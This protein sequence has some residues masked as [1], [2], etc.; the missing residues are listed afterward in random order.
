MF[1]ADDGEEMTG[2]VIGRIFGSG[3]VEWTE[4]CILCFGVELLLLWLLLY[5]L[6]YL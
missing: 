6:L 2:D 1:N 4:D 3:L 5:Y